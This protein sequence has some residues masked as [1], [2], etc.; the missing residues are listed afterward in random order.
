M[1][2]NN[3]KTHGIQDKTV[4]IVLG[5]RWRSVKKMQNDPWGRK[6]GGKEQGPPDLMRLFGNVWIF[7]LKNPAASLRLRQRVDSV[8]W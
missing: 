4:N 6:A 7:R 8:V 3:D 2:R 1:N 5:P